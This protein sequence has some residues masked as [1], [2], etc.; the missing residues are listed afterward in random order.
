MNC[1][2]T[3]V[4]THA[5]ASKMVTAR[6][7]GILLVASETALRP[8]PGYAGYAATK[9]F[10]LVLGESLWYELREYGV[11]VFSF[12][13]GPTN[14]PGLRSAV[15]GLEEG[16]VRGAI[17]LPETTAEA[18]IAALGRAASAAREPEHEALLEARRRLA[19]TRIAEGR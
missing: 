11:D 13:P 15:P 6:R 14:T 5:F 1:A 3:I 2:A 18:A 17:Q 12:V 7:G 4:L 8:S 10:D 19:E 9:A 16:Q